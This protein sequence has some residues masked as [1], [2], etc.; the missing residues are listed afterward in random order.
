MSFPKHF[1]G[2]V[3]VMALVACGGGGGSAGSVGSTSTN[4]SATGT[5][6]EVVAT[7]QVAKPSMTLDVLSGAGV[8]TNSISASEISTVSVVLKDSAG[9]SVPGT[10]VVF[11]ESGGSLLSVAPA[12][13]T[14]LTDAA[15]KAS[16]E[17]RAATT[18]SVGATTISALAQVSGAPVT[19]QKSI[20]ITSAPSGGAVIDPQSIANAMNFL[21]VNPADKSIVL[22]GSGGNGRSE[23]ATLRFRV[24][25]KNNTPVKGAAVTFDVIPVNSVTLNIPSAV[26][27]ADGVVV[28][29]VSSKSF[30]TA[31]VVRGTVTRSNSSTI[32]SQSDQLLVTTGSAV[33]RGFDLSA[34]KYNLNWDLSGDLSKIT[35]RIV[36]TNG[37]PVADGV[38]VVFTADFG[39]VGSSARGGCVTSNG[40]CSVDYTVQ[41]P[42]PID[43]QFATVIVSTQIG[44]GTSISQSLQFRFADPRLLNVF[45]FGTGAAVPTF[46][47]NSSCQKKI[48]SA[49]AGTPAGFPA[50]AGTTVEVAPVTPAF[51]ASL[52]FG[53]PILDRVGGRSPLDFELDVAPIT[54]TDACVATGARTKI[55]EFNV[56][57]TA[58]VTIVTRR[59]AVTYPI[60]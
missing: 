19:A 10:V 51:A 38:P 25:D 48:F 30:A 9:V 1:S 26:S 43:G 27:D 28:T 12:S 59:I 29:T 53:S 55:A 57:F 45:E 15:G 7:V 58:G 6:T 37:N 8:S 18:S 49:F 44:D 54:G 16:V 52:K 3:M 14:A 20:A 4:A 35:V 13:K 60:L 32:T 22:A 56:K 42:R 50:P 33:P 47:F 31:V 21:D 11:T 2:F 40:S 46:A 17:I 36:D 24:V 39:A 41:D 34:S 23:S 5:V